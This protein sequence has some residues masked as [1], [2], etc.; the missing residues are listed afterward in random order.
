MEGGEPSTASDVPMPTPNRGAMTVCENSEYFLVFLLELAENPWLAS[1]I[2]NL[3]CSVGNNHI[4]DIL[5]SALTPT[6][7]VGGYRLSR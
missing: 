3:F 5:V 6:Q 7:T 4:Q 1:R 2:K